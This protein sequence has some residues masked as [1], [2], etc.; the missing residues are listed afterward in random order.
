MARERAHDDAGDEGG[1]HGQRSRR[2]SVREGTFRS[3][4]RCTIC[5]TKIRMAERSLHA[6]GRGLHRSSAAGFRRIK[7]LPDDLTV[8]VPVQM[9]S[10]PST[11]AALIA[12]AVLLRPPAGHAQ[13]FIPR[14]RWSGTLG[15]ITT[16]AWDQRSR[17]DPLVGGGIA[18]AADLRANANRARVKIAK[19]QQETKLAFQQALL[20]AGAGGERALAQ[21]QSAR[22]KADLRVQQI[23]ALGARRG[24]HGTADEA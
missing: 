23:E 1:R 10:N 7:R 17:Q 13:P 15:W 8:G 9:L 24:E 16:A 14:S 21:C 11:S 6:A 5:N 12:H 20:N 2:R 3:K 19:A 4:R 22:A 18:S